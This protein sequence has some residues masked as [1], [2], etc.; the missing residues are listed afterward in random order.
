MLRGAYRLG[1]DSGRLSVKTARTGFGRRAGHDLT[2]EVTR[3]SAEA[4]ADPEAL[5]NSSVSL[6]AEA[7]SLEPRQGTGGIK[8]LTDSDRA[9]IK[10]IAA[11]ILRT[12]EHPAITFRSVS[13]SGGPESFTVDGE[14]TIL[15]RTRPV[16]VRGSADARLIRARATVVQSDFGITPYSAF[17]GALKLADEVEIEF[18]AT[19]P[20][21]PS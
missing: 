15:G 3:W 9:E 21:S 6:R 2:I 20:A 14:L 13:V 1:P 17:F 16:T 7:G 18:S 8:P 12:T 11:R 4:V 10:R 5:E 19:P